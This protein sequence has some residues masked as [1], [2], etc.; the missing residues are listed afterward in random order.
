MTFWL[1]K[2]ARRLARKIKIRIFER[3][4]DGQETMLFL[5]HHHDLVAEEELEVFVAL[6]AFAAE[7]GV[8]EE[9]G[10]VPAAVD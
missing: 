10:V 5:V 6:P 2:E 9:A 3:K 4:S 8:P 7:V 1:H